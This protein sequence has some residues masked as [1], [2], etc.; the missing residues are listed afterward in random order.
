MDDEIKALAERAQK[1]KASLATE[2]AT[3][4]ALVMPFIRLLGY[5]VFNPHEVVPEFVADVAGRK[6]EKVDYAIMDAD[7]PIMIIE[8]KTCGAALD[9]EKCEQLHRYF[10]T[11]DTSIG[12]LTDGIR[13]LFYS[14]GDDGKKMDTRPFM[15]INLDHLDPALIPELKKLC[16]GKFDLKTTLETVSELRYNRHIKRLLEQNISEPDDDFLKYFIRKAELSATQKVIDQFGGYVKRAF[17]EFLNEQVNSRLK[18]ALDVSQKKDEQAQAQVAPQPDPEKEVVTDNEFQA[19]YVVK[20]ILAGI[21][22]A[23]RVTLRNITGIGRSIIVLDDSIRKP[24]LRLFLDKP[25]SWTISLIGA[26]KENIDHKITAVDDILK[27][28]EAIKAA[29][30]MYETKPAKAQAPAAPVTPPAPPVPPQ[31]ST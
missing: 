28:A 31:S 27:H 18:T 2:E 9:A 24:V 11:L 17:M 3:K 16:K 15:E 1:L 14:K 26:N 5:D 10:L 29:A 7:K 13:Y 20:A 25:G 22:D 19:L 21:T 6:G 8:C 4:T 23:K 12:I 30:R